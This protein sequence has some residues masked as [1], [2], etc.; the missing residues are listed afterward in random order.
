MAEKIAMRIKGV[1]LELKPFIAS[2]VSDKLPTND[3]LISPSVRRFIWSWDCG[4]QQGV[5]TQDPPPRIPIDTEFLGVAPEVKNLKARKNQEKAYLF[6]LLVATD[7]SPTGLAKEISSAFKPQIFVPNWAQLVDPHKPNQRFKVTLNISYLDIVAKPIVTKGPL[8]GASFLLRI[9]TVFSLNIDFGV[10]C[11]GPAAAPVL[12]R[13]SIPM[14]EAVKK[15]NEANDKAFNDLLDNDELWT[16]LPGPG[17]P[18]QDSD[19]F[20]PSPEPTPT[21]P[22]EDQQFII[23]PEPYTPEII[24]D[25]GME[26]GEGDTMLT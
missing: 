22:G 20:K 13:V 10:P 23:E 4:K 26:G 2:K 16:P 5:R 3:P 14:N 21:P 25:E 18:L 8:K 1:T 7:L 17:G 6:D 24:Y 12:K 19:P 9:P 15:L 11:S